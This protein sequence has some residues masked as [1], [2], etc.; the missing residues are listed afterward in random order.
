MS[1]DGLDWPGLMAA[2]LRELGL[3][4]WEFWALTPHELQVMLGRERSAMPVSFHDFDALLARFPDEQHP[5]DVAD[6]G[7]NEHG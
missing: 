4:P 7:E 6:E 1:A 3:K 5:P 2:G